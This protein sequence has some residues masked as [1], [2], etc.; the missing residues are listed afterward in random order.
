[1]HATAEELHDLAGAYV[2][3][4]ILSDGQLMV[5]RHMAGCDACY[6]SFCAKYVLLNGLNAYKLIPL[7]MEEEGELQEEMGKE[8][9]LS[10]RMEGENP[11]PE[12]TEGIGTGLGKELKAEA[13]VV[14]KKIGD[15]FTLIRQRGESL[16]ACWE[17]FER[18]QLAMVRGGD[19]AV[20]EKA[21]VSRQSEESS[22]LC[23][24]DQ[25]TI[26]LEE[27]IFTG[28]ELK[29]QAI[30]DGE[31]KTYSFSYDEDLGCYEAVLDVGNMKEGAMIRIIKA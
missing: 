27:G 10:E 20:K 26:Q 18:P 4:E 6:Q 29:L 22:I 11:L 7:E 16:A 28:E 1:M 21:Y 23:G 24:K 3:E 19:S 12:E 30:N 2:K 14:L 13:F 17:F 15:A 25:I 5:K 31:E 8:R 9:Q